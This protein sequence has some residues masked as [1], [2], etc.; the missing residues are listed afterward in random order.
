MRISHRQLTACLED[1]TAWLQRSRA[2]TVLRWSYAYA[3]EVA[4]Y[5]FHQANYRAAALRHLA[6]TFAQRGMTSI[7]RQHLAE[8][9]LLQYIGWLRAEQPIFAMVRMQVDLDLGHGWRLGGLVSR[10]DHDLES[11]GY[12][13]V[14]FGDAGADWDE[15]LRMPLLQ[16]A[17]ASRVHRPEHEVSVGVQGLD[18]NDLETVVYL[19]PDI[20]EALRVARDLARRLSRLV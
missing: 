8:E 7:E 2:G 9:R 1:P 5:R 20:D 14:L 6:E 13:A 11:E 4:I 15:E 3:T 16:R 10:V 18:G 19:A 17:V 12:R